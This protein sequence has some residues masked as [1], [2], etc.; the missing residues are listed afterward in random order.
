M[1]SRLGVN[2]WKIIWE[3]YKKIDK[4]PMSDPGKKS[5]EYSEKFAKILKIFEKI[6][7]K[8]E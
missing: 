8:L 1:L 5:E 7:K 3:I 2:I 6:L 4:M